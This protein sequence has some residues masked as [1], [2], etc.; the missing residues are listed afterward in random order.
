[1]NSFRIKYPNLLGK[2]KEMQFNLL[3]QAEYLREQ[4]L[5]IMVVY[6][7][8]MSQL[9]NS[10]VKSEVFN[11]GD[12]VLKWPD[13]TEGDVRSGELG[14]NWKGPYRVSKVIHSGCC[15]LS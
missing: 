15:K 10:Q 8:K 7:N 2:P 6:K 13:V 4:I 12:L 5:I 14:E 11:V 9:F 1:M 3:D